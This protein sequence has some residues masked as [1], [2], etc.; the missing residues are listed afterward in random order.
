MTRYVQLQYHRCNDALEK[1]LLERIRRQLNP[2][3]GRIR[4]LYTNNL[5]F[6]ELL[7]SAAALPPHSAIYWY[8]MLVAAGV[9]HEGG[10]ALARLHAVANAPI[11]TYNDAYFGPELLGGPMQSVAANGRLALLFSRA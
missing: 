2:L 1:I 6:E 9:G 4:L 7:K 8:A 10:A 5:S 3:E 11:F